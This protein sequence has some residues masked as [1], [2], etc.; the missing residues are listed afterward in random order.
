MKKKLSLKELVSRIAFCRCAASAVFLVFVQGSLQ[1]ACAQGFVMPD[2]YPSASGNRAVAYSGE[3]MVT[4]A[5]QSDPRN[6]ARIHTELGALYFRDGN[7]AVA[8]E[9]LRIAL[10]IDSK[11]EHAYAMRGLINFY[12]GERQ[13]AEE[14][15]RKALGIAE[16]DPEINNNYGTFLCQTGRVEESIGYFMRAAKNPS[17]R[18]PDLA[19]LNAGQCAAMAGDDKTAEEYLSRSAR[20]APRP[21]SITMVEQAGI[22]YRRGAY[23]EA[24]RLLSNA[25][26][27]GSPDAKALWLSVRVERKLGNYDSSQSYAAQLQRQFPDSS[28][29]K[30]MRTGNY[31]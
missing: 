15:Y 22:R 16:N 11:Y 5:T 31:E 17:Y 6:R 4:E 14:D 2:T 19:Y 8:L 26:R 21:S 30:N 10:E 20:L 23:E 24:R 27:S 1:I 12:T 13:E 9:E 3:G 18:T 25:R 29:V 7:V 28:E